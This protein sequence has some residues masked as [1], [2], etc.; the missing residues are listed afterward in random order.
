MNTLF[1]KFKSAV[2]G[3]ALF[4]LGCAMAGM[5]LVVVALLALFALVSVGAALLA[6]PFIAMAQSTADAEEDTR[7]D[8][9]V[10][11]DLSDSAA[12]V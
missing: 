6:S 10:K 2:S 8:A 11:D 3:I 9:Q 7:D 4:S 5:G 1:I 12:T